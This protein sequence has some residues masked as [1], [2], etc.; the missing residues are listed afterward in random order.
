MNCMNNE[1]IKQVVGFQTSREAWCMLEKHFSSKS[2]P[3]M[4]QLKEEFQNFK[5]QDLK[6]NDYV[7]KI[8]ELYYKLEGVDFIVTNEEKLMYI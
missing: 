4:I 6:V 3:Q 7:L 8:K 1:L 5:K 2:Q